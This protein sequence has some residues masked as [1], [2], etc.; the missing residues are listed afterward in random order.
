MLR[1]IVIS[2]KHL[3]QSLPPSFNKSRQN[4]YAKYSDNDP[5][6]LTLTSG[7]YM[8]SDS[9]SWVQLLSIFENQAINITKQ[10]LCLLKNLTAFWLAPLGVCGQS[11][12]I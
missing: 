9:R 11:I 12:T 7:A 6:G 4:Y 3:A 10:L 8:S 5:L 1:N 2:Y